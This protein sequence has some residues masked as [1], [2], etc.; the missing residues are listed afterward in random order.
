MCSKM[1]TIFDL[2]LFSQIFVLHIIDQEL[3]FMAHV[4]IDTW[5]RI[6]VKLK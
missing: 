5:I 2:G 4:S 3:L 1:S 6:P